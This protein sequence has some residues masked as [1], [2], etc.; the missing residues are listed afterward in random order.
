MAA[1]QGELRLPDV[2]PLPPGTQMP[3]SEDVN[4]FNR[5]MTGSFEDVGQPGYLS[6]D[7]EDDDQ[8]ASIVG[9]PSPG[10]VSVSASAPNLSKGSPG[11]S[12]GGGRPSWL[13]N[14]T[15]G[16]AFALPNAAQIQR[17]SD[18]VEE[19][20]HTIRS[21]IRASSYF[22]GVEDWERLFKRADTD[23]NG[24]V[25]HEELLKLIAGTVKG[26]A[27]GFEVAE[28]DVRAL[29]RFL[30]VDGDGTISF[31]EFQRFLEGR[32]NFRI[33]EA[34]QATLMAELRQ[35]R[36][37][38]RSNF[39]KSKELEKIE[40]RRKRHGYADPAR[41]YGWEDVEFTS[42]P[43]ATR[44][45]ANKGT[46]R[47]RRRRPRPVNPY[48]DSKYDPAPKNE[49]W[50][51]SEQPE[52][53]HSRPDG[54]LRRGRPSVRLCARKRR[55]TPTALPHSLMAGGKG[56]RQW[57]KGSMCMTM[58]RDNRPK[59]GQRRSRPDQYFSP[60][61]NLNYVKQLVRIRS[62]IQRSLFC[63]T[64][65]CACVHSRWGGGF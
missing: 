32:I 3:P 33:S 27:K 25:D 13:R 53:F 15:G 10:S 22:N 54:A 35:A 11:K 46:L 2:M 51:G 39:R 9:S 47:E 4:E 63:L 57:S 12:D 65:A 44:D 26:S 48:Y 52:I 58:T 23:G 50:G 18:I 56:L 55:G 43:Q 5:S 38:R 49:H 36:A 41:P 1:P 28:R 19:Q 61:K 59:P 24:N 40:N 7:D 17:Q 37:G 6:E 29:F 21:K 60:E 62:F 34:E 45:L 30:D 64:F 16:P 42:V 20:L 8:L 31:P 14:A